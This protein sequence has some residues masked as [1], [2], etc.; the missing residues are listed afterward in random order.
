MPAPSIQMPLHQYP[1]PSACVHSRGPH[2]AVG[3]P[4]PG[5][6]LAAVDATGGA[7]ADSGP[8]STDADMRDCTSQVTPAG[9][10]AQDQTRTRVTSRSTT[11][12][13][14]PLCNSKRITRSSAN[15]SRVTAASHVIDPAA[16]HEAVAVSVRDGLKKEMSATTFCGRWRHLLLPQP[17]T[18]PFTHK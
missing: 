6:T 13:S 2:S 4:A 11:P 3:H 9:K 17:P 12:G 10:G 7:S 5:V 8:A 14:T 15:R 18:Q 1:S 16:L